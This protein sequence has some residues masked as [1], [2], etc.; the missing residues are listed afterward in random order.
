MMQL[1]LR[2]LMKVL[3]CSIK[4]QE[5]GKQRKYRQYK[6]NMNQRRNRVIVAR[7]KKEIVALSQRVTERCRL[8]WLTKSAL[9]YEP[10]CGGGGG[11]QLRGLSQW[12]QVYY[13]GAQI[14][15]WDLIPYLTYAPSA[16]HPFYGRCFTTTSRYPRNWVGCPRINKNKFRFE[17][18]Q[19][20]TRSVSRLFWFVSWNQKQKISVC[21]GVSNLYRD[22][23]NKQVCFV[24]NRKKPKQTK[25]N[26]NN[27]KF[28]EKYPNILSFKLFGW[29]LC[30]FRFNRNMETLCFGI[31]AKQPKQM[32]C[33][34]K[35][36]N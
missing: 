26:R 17:P 14:T 15:F 27:R 21:F 16:L 4:Y 23:R 8:S 10:K 36:R 6:L 9:V 2:T 12:V 13:T 19:T 3:K 29:V 20:E 11:G 33:F 18:K 30:L 25:T 5:G 32:F 28:S 35:C 1:S 7:E 24:T 31:E 34:G 22:N